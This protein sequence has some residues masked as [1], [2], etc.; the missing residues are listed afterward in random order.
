MSILKYGT[1]SLAVCFILNN[2]SANA[3]APTALDD[4]KKQNVYPSFIDCHTHLIFAG[5]RSNEFEMRNQGVS[6]QNIARQGGGIISTVKH[7]RKAKLADLISEGQKRVLDLLKQGVT[8]VEIKSGYG[9]SV[10]AELK[11]LRVIKTLKERFKKQAEQTELFLAHEQSW[12]GKKIVCGDFNN[13]AYSWVYNQISS[14]KKDAFIEAG[15]GFGK[16]FD[17]FLPTRID[18]I[19][20]DKGAIINNFKTHKIIYSDHYAISSRVNW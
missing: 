7:T 12:N 13:T 17:Y 4:L 15:K 1:Y 10:D 3:Q 18:F 16:T 19:L 5:N 8:T 6:Y 9:L 14:D 20:T 11:M 2:P